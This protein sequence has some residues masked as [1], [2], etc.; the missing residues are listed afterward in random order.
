MS[1]D[2]LYIFSAFHYDVAYRKTFDNYLPQSFEAIDR[3]LDLLQANPEFVFNIEQIILLDAYWQAKPERQETIRQ[4]AQDERLIFC[5]GMWTMPDGN[6]PNAESCYR[7]VM[8][9]RDWLLEHLGV[10]PGP[11]CWMADI[12]GHHNQSP[13]IYRQLGYQ[14]YM[15]ERGQLLDET[16]TD[17]WWEGLDGSRIATHWE[18][19]TYYGLFLALRWDR[20]ESWVA[21][22]LRLRILE[23]LHKQRHTPLLS[24]IG[25]DFLISEQQHVDFV[26]R[27]N[28][29]GETPRI[30]FAHPRKFLQENELDKTI[31][32]DLNPLMQGT[33]SSRIRLKQYNRQIESLLY[34]LE[35]RDAALGQ[36][37]DTRDLW[38]ALA[39]HQFHDIICGSLA[40]DAWKESL[41]E[42]QELQAAASDA[43]A[44]SDTSVEPHVFNP[45][46]YSRTEIIE[47]PDG[48]T[49]IR[50]GAME[51]RPLAEAH[52]PAE[53]R[54]IADAESR[55]LAN[56]YLEL[57][58][59]AHGRLVK[60]TDRRSGHTYRDHRH[61]YL[62]DVGMEPDY[63]DPWIL[64]RGPV[65]G[66]QLH[67][68]PYHDPALLSATYIDT[69]SPVRARINDSIG[70]DL[71]T[72]T[73]SAA[74]G[75]EEA[76]LTCP[77]GTHTVIYSLRADEPL[78][79][80]RVHFTPH[81]QMR[82][83]AVMP[84]GL[85]HGHIRREIPAGWIA[86][87]EGEYPTQSWMDVADSQHG[88]CLLNRGLPGN[89]TT[90]DIMLLTLFRSGVLIQPNVM[91]DYEVNSEHQADYA[92]CPFSVGD[93]G[94]DPCRLGRLFN[95]PPVL[96][97]PSPGE[98]SSAWSLELQGPAECLSIR[99]VD[100]EREV[101]LHESSGAGSDVVLRSN[102][103][104]Q[105][106]RRVT[107]FGEDL[108]P[109]EV[110]GESLRL[111]LRPFEILTLRLIC[112]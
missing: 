107:P 101:R 76:L 60:L 96:S 85:R 55:S 71:P 109:L 81:I 42:A 100:G 88:L 102:R 43:L 83:R 50:L 13:Q 49:R 110:Q 53:T 8:L 15:F 2:T 99:M 73:A 11:I 45:L 112:T 10:E 37:S 30:Q 66:S 14:L 91:P 59:D 69:V 74:T 78:L 25:G 70:L 28:E 46:P 19:D 44:G 52:C 108:E 65:N 33:Y 29:R 20:P 1:A 40:E 26:R 5:P 105:G 41:A 51:M 36:A 87:P 35:A 79:R 58:L 9:G 56:E 72:I 31:R 62:H 77:Y 75:G 111:Q 17:F 38:R 103:P 12:F 54:V 94:Y 93:P 61:G 32:G 48:P 86:Q 7:N 22:R 6:L 64:H 92:L 39:K 95:Q 80:I 3:G 27:W 82:L 106:A 34:A 24:K 57:E 18:A 67:I 68:T 63:G 4:F 16:L 97:F 104:L 89:N 47:T 90:D 98:A 84:T 23:P 21:D